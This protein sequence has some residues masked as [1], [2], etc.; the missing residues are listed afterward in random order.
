[1][2]IGNKLWGMHLIPPIPQQTILRVYL[3]FKQQVETFPQSL[4]LPHIYGSANSPKVPD[5]DIQIKK[6][7]EYLSVFSYMLLCR[8]FS[9]SADVLFLV[10]A[11]NRMLW[12]QCWRL[13]SI[14]RS[15]L[16]GNGWH[17]QLLGVICGFSG[18][19]VAVIL[20]HSKKMRGRQ[21]IYYSI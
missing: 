21:K 17:F 5:T 10:F 16:T 8:A 2:H 9:D 20:P 19:F 7:A 1:M 11:G 4:S 6:S 13:M 15:R 12:L 3:L 14:G 18:G